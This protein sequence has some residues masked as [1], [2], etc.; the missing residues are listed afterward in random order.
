[1]RNIMTKCLLIIFG[2]ALFISNVSAGDSAA[3][4]KARMNK[5][6]S[7]VKALKVKGIVGENNKG[8]LEFVGASKEGADVVFAENSDRS[9]VY[10]AIAKQ[11]GSAAELVGKLR[12]SKIA[13]LAA[14]GEWIQDASGKWI[15]K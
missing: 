2:T 8:F 14:K 4:I 12:A 7:Q 13:S 9:K 10:A 5:R 6:I 11:Q 3:D 15:K 1:M